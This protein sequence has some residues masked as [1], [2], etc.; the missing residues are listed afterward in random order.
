MSPSS[1]H[2]RS[3]SPRSTQA[4][5]YQ[6][7]EYRADEYRAPTYEPAEYRPPAADPDETDRPE[8]ARQP[9]EP[10]EPEPRDERQRTTAPPGAGTPVDRATGSD[11]T[12]GLAPVLD[13]L[14]RATSISERK[15]TLAQLGSRRLTDDEARALLSA[16]RTAGNGAASH[17]TCSTGATSTR[18]RHRRCSP[19]SNDRATA[20]S[21]LEPCSIAAPCAP[22]TS[23]SCCHRGQ[24]VAWWPAEERDVEGMV[25]LVAGS[26]WAAGI[27]LYAVVALLGIYG[28]T[29]VGEVP[30]VFTR[31]D[32][33]A[34]AVALFAVEFVVDKIPYLDSLW[35]LVHS[36]VRPLGALGVA[37]L[38]TG[39]AET[40]QQLTSGVAAGGVA[41]ASHLAKA[42]ARAAINTSPEPASNVGVSLG[43]DGLV[44][45]VVWLAVTNPAVALAA[46]ILLL[47]AGAVLTVTMFNVAR[48]G[49]RRMR[50][51]RRSGA[52]PPPVSR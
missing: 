48:R 20:S 8:S 49:W 28:R 40:W 25:G 27:N 10:A 23:T 9:A 5:E 52:A 13:G 29:G 24:P 21:S 11:A 19:P 30:D 32:V 6:A 37:L 26:A 12:A 45:G 41:S 46:V 44:A 22:P 33:I 36:V 16:S 31:T 14:D 50:E 42:T 1:T 47:V 2:R 4:P 7:L 18:W 43:E 38:L 35:D 34:V 15:A 3:T 17:A 39:E 51:R